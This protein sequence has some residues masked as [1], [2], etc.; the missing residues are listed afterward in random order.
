MFLGEQF[1]LVYVQDFI[2]LNTSADKRSHNFHLLVLNT[3]MGICDQ[4][5]DAIKIITIEM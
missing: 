1:Q 2:I 4:M 3:A 5:Y